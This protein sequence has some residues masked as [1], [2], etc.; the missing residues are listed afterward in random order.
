MTEKQIELLKLVLS[1]E[2]TEEQWKE[3]LSAYENS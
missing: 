3:V 2:L 1:V